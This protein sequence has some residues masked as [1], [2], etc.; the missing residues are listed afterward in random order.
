MSI[1]PTD[2]CTFW[3]TQEY[4]AETGAADFK[5]RVGAFRFPSCTS[6]A[7]GALSGAVTDGTAPLPGATVTATP[8][9]SRPVAS[10]SSSTT[11]DET[12]H[13]QFLT[14]PAGT[15]DVTAAKF[16]YA[17]ATASG[18]VV[19]DGGAA[20]RDFALQALPSVVVNGTVTDGSGQGWP[21]YARL[22][23]SG[24]PGFSGAVLFTDPV[25]GYYSISLPT[26]GAYAF[27]V[28]AVGPGY[29]PGGGPLSLA[30]PAGVNAPVVASWKLSAAPT[31]DAPGYGPGDFSGAPALSE[32]FD[33]GVLPSGWTIDTTSGTS[34][35][36]RSGAGPC[37]EFDGNRT[38]G[39]GAYA[40]IDSSCFSDGSTPDDSSL[41]TPS[42]DLTGRS[43]AAI[44][45]ASDFVDMGYG[46]VGTVDVSTDA[47]VTWSNIWRVSQPDQP[48]PSAPVADL[49]FAAGHAGVK[50]RFHYQGVWAWWWQVDD[51][52]VGTYACTPIPGGLVVGTVGDANTGAGL[53]DATVANAAGGASAKTFATPE[54]PAQGDGFFILFSDSGAQSIQAAYPAH[55]PQTKSAT[56]I[57]NGTMRLDF[58]LAAGLL[59][60]SPRPLSL[61]VSPGAAE[62]LTLTL[63]NTGTGAA[64]F[65]DPGA[66]RAATGAAGVASGHARECRGSQGRVEAH[67]VLAA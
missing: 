33:A 13:Y 2:D 16:G 36:I 57:P 61:S 45:F 56:V 62:D 4:Y 48:G 31:C 32:S 8:S 58:S 47:G 25:T 40:L 14:L 11:T 23:V 64:H 44:R 22:A 41:V 65:R 3:Y 9:G 54:D 34:W 55:D 15:Y 12:G 60:A 38:G 1:D 51:V 18:V 39:S 46:A 50:A 67:S 7:A 37:G 5:T 49:S 10:G 52:L 30:A 35:M 26:G 19:P 17:S 59:Q 21:L 63:S 20:A 27:A 42:F 66:L 53:D 28:T 6:G 29:V 43:S 24:P